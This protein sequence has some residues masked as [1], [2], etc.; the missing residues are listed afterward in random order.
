MSDTTPIR[1]SE[2]IRHHFPPDLADSAA[3]EDFYDA[4]LDDVRGPAITL[5]ETL[6]ERLSEEEN[7]VFGVEQIQRDRWFLFGDLRPLKSAASAL[8]KLVRDIDEAERLQAGKG[9]RLAVKE[10]R[11]RLLSFKDLGRCRIVCTLNQDVSYLLGVLLQDSRFLGCYPMHGVVKDF[12][13]EPQRRGALKGHRARQLSVW[14]KAE[15]CRFGFEVQLMT[16]LQHAWDRRNHPLYEWMR[17]G[18][19]LTDVLRVNDFACSEALHLVD[20]Q[21]ERNWEMFLEQLGRKL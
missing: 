5:V 4:L 16:T 12:V 18:G 17:E 20:Q 2:V 19:N 10:I 13:F 8:S 11:H 3:F 9:E 7:K 15:S 6:R 21:G 1:C 14:I